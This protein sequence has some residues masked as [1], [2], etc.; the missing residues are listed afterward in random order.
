MFGTV[1]AGHA[2]SISPSLRTTHSLPSEQ[3]GHPE[4]Q[5]NTVSRV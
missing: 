2:H 4:T 3:T 5:V 1:P